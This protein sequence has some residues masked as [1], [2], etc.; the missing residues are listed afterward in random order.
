MAI[1]NLEAICDQNL[2]YAIRSFDG[3]LSDVVAMLSDKQTYGGYKIAEINEA[4]I[5]GRNLQSNRDE[6]IDMA[7]KPISSSLRDTVKYM[8]GSGAIENRQSHE[9]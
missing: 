5:S 6:M 3:Y 7:Y 4:L 2:S 9:L 1:A 8:L